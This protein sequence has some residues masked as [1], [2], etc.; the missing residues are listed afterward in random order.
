MPIRAVIAD[1]EPPARD[2][3]A[4]L[5][6]R[7]PDVEVVAQAASAREA[8]AAI[9]QHA[10]DV[11]FLDIEMPGGSGLDV[12]AE[13]LAEGPP[14]PPQFVFA[15][16]FD[17]YAIRAF[18]AN[19]VDYLL[20]PVE[21]DRLARSLARVRGSLA[22]PKGPPPGREAVGQEVLRLLEAMSPGRGLTRVAVEQG[23]RIALLRP[24]EVVFLGT[25]ERRV[26]AHTARGALPCHG[27]VTLE[28]L[29]ERLGPHSFFRANRGA[30]VNLARVREF[31]PW[32]N[33]KYACTMDDAQGTEI[34]VSRGRVAAFKERLGL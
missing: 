17:H 34:T 19:A 23:G 31:S 5:L 21:A 29:E 2:E 27:P 32:F 18:E 28:T 4:F 8:V 3:L 16:A 1:D 11:A 26:V 10:P 30:L 24:E 12:V 9:R 6:S 13:V 7:F 25:E 20:K 33:G 15:T 22:A 14:V